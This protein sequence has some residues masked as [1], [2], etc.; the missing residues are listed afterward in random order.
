MQDRK[1][2][3]KENTKKRVTRN[4]TSAPQR[5]GHKWR[6]QWT[7]HTGKRRSKTFDTFDEA[8]RELERVKGARRLVQDGSLPAP[9]E[10]ITFKEFVKTYYIPNRTE[11]TRCPRNDHSIFKNHLYTAFN[12]F[13]LVDIDLRVIESFK[14]KK[15]SG[16][17]HPNTLRHILTLLKSVLRYAHSMEFLLRVPAFKMPKIPE[18]PYSYIR[19]DG[20]IRALLREAKKET[21]GV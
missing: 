2:K 14:G 20:G 9:P 21:D 15:L 3:A 10:P 18:R 19:T 11:Q 12:D 4:R 6:I 17:M 8:N 5:R 7:D 1:E 13:N 16:G